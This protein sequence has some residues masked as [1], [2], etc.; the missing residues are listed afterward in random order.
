[1]RFFD[2][3]QY[4]ILQYLLDSDG[5]GTTGIRWYMSVEVQHYKTDGG[6]TDNMA[7]FHNSLATIKLR[8]EEEDTV[9]H[10]TDEAFNQVYTKHG[11]FQRNGPK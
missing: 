6:R 1:M 2:H 8:E 4:D 9:I 3:R 7:D 11:N 10:T 5:V